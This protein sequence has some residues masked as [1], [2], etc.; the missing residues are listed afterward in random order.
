MKHGIYLLL[1]VIASCSVQD[2][3]EI[4]P[5]EDRIPG[6]SESTIIVEK[7]ASIPYPILPDFGERTK[8]DIV[9]GENLEV[10]TWSDSRI[11][12]LDRNANTLMEFDRRSGRSKVIAS[13]GRG[14]GDLWFSSSLIRRGTALYVSL[15]DKRM[16]TFDCFVSPC[17]FVSEVKLPIAP[18]SAVLADSRFALLGTRPITSPDPDLINEATTS[19]AI[20]VVDIEGNPV[21]NFGDT[22]DYQGNWMLLTYFA[23]GHI[24]QHNPSNY[25]VLAFETF[26][27]LQLF[28]RSFN[29]VRNVRFSEF[30]QSKFLHDSATGMVRLQ[31]GDFSQISNIQPIGND[32]LIEITTRKNRRRVDDVTK[33]DVTID[34]YRM[35]GANGDI[36]YAGTHSNPDIKTYFV[37]HGTVLQVNGD[38][39]WIQ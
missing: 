13:E 7:P 19:K 37:D 14:P 24:R 33:W 38:L 32:L 16:A 9:V 8:L 15:G 1:L 28:D 12:I 3:E 17:E 25:L 10:I 29:A 34:Y 18:K 31:Q 2:R 27:T 26:P 23:D 21:A 36:T 35:S 20:T 5:I 30:V 22:Y 4:H 39:H 6:L 11:I